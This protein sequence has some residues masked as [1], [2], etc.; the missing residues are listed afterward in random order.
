M[1]WQ[2]ILPRAAT[3]LGIVCLAS[4][5]WGEAEALQVAAGAIALWGPFAALLYIWL[6]PA[7]PDRGERLTLSLTGS[8]AATALIYFALAVLQAGWLF[9]WAQIAA[10]ASLATIASWRKRL[11][12]TFENW[13]DWKVDWWLAALI[14]ATLLISVRY[15]VAFEFSPTDGTRHFRLYHDQTYHTALAYELQRHVPPLQ[16]PTQAGKPDRAYHLFPHISTMLLARY[17]G[18]RDLLHTQTTWSFVV[19]T[20]LICLCLH[21]LVRSIARANGAGYLAV[22]LLFILSVP[23]PPL[24]ENP[25]GYFYFSLYPHATSLLEPVVMTTPQMYSGLVVFFGIMLGLA[26]CDRALMQ[27]PSGGAPDTRLA[28]APHTELWRIMILIG[29]MTGALLRFRAHIF[30]PFAPLF[31][32]AGIWLA[33]R[34]RDWRLI[35][36]AGIATVISLALLFE[37]RQPVYQAGTAQFS[38]GYNSLTWP[39]TEEQPNPAFQWWWLYWPGAQ[40][41]FRFISGALP[42]AA[43]MW[44]WHTSCISGFVLFQ[45]VGIPLA[46]AVAIYFLKPSSWKSQRLLAALILSIVGCS[47][48]GAMV[49][50]FKGESYSLAGQM[51]LHTCWYLFPILPAMLWMAYEHT[52]IRQSWNKQRVTNVAVGVLAVAILYQSVRG[53]SSLERLCR[54]MG[55][56]LTANEWDAMRFL[57]DSTPNAAVVLMPLRPQPGLAPDGQEAQQRLRAE[58]QNFAICG[59]IGGRATYIEYA[60]APQD[61][62]RVRDVVDLWQTPD[63]KDFSKQVRDT[64]AT[65]LVEYPGYSPKCFEGGIPPCLELA[66]ESTAGTSRV[67]I[68]KITKADGD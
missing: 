33:W 59:S 67:R 57:R 64:K 23:L 56:V 10:I 2:L 1:Q 18:Q 52:S 63:Q 29:A 42:K 68:W 15:R 40:T 7:V 66:W 48:L 53:P 37:M 28:D 50:N 11:I 39:G 43:A 49:L 12:A 4:F 14:V 31:G 17:A 25:L 45:V 35:A 38:L 47:I 16:Q 61:V 32:L 20:V 22:A 27:S 46:A 65:H 9:P 58:V 41:I 26:I 8:Y 13:R 62:E 30:L 3:L 34:F 24:I 19:M 5:E 6:Q 51:L 36:G 60:H 54:N 44:A 55:F 21:H